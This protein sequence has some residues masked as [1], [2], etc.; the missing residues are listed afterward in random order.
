[1][2]PSRRSSLLL[3][4]SLVGFCLAQSS[5]AITTTS[6]SSI[7]IAGPSWGGLEACAETCVSGHYAILASSFS[8]TNDDC[9]CGSSQSTAVNTAFYN[10]GF[11][12]NGTAE[13]TSVLSRFSSY[14]ATRGGAT[15]PTPTPT[16]SGEHVISLVT[17][18]PPEPTSLNPLDLPVNNETDITAIPA[19]S[20]LKFCAQNCLTRV[21]ADK[22]ASLACPTTTRAGCLCA[23]T[24]RLSQQT[25]LTT[26]DT[27]RSTRTNIVTVVNNRLVASAIL[28]CNLICPNSASAGEAAV[29]VFSSYCA[30]NLGPTLPS[31]SNG[32]AGAT[33][34]PAQ[35]GNTIIA[36]QPNNTAS[37]SSS[38]GGTQGGGL[39]SDGKVGL[40]VGLGVGVP[41]MIIAA[42]GVWVTIYFKRASR[43]RKEKQ[44]RQSQALAMDETGSMNTPL[45]PEPSYEFQAGSYELQAGTLA[46]MN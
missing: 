2:K 36:T 34:G 25:T 45:R 26:W 17:F 38:N 44:Q 42:V 11:G 6:T 31:S 15:A 23:T 12:C 4:S 35:P 18:N 10:C 8:C 46:E 39:S 28:N 27:T 41:S 13:A 22:A 9:L 5:P 1:M 20:D 37:S 16:G 29:K 40:G 21:Y 7:S 30:T 24:T 14:C 3:L 19:I 33:S 32:A 43:R